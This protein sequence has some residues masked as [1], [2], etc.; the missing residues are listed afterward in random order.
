MESDT[1]LDS[2]YILKVEPMR[3]PDG[4]NY[5]EGDGRNQGLL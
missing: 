3:V 5:T 4:L 2:G 1:S